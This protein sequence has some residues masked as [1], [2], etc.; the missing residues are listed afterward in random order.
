[1]NVQVHSRNMPFLE[2]FSSETRVKIIEL[3]G[4]QPMNIK[5]LAEAL[6]I[7]SAIVTK[8]IQK[9]EDAGIVGTES[10]SG[11]RG[12]RKVCRLLPESVTLQ[13]KTREL[14][15]R[16]RYEVSI[17]IG[18]YS[19]CQVKPT[20]GLASEDA[21]I[22]MIDDPRYFSDPDHIRAKHIWFGSGYLE[23]RIPNYLVGS[24]KVRS[25]S[26]SLEICSE[27]PGYNENWPSD[28]TFYLNGMAVGTWTC[29]GDFG[30]TPGVYTPQWWA[31]GTQHGLLKT[32]H[33]RPD[34][35]YM[36]GVRMSDVKA[37][38]LS[39][40]VGEDIRFRI[41]CHD[42]A[43]HCGGVSLFGRQFGNYDQEI[44]VAVYYED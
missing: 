36:D 25:L 43:R 8:H 28:L 7:S 27:A 38:D 4:E 18:Q 12:R 20:C 31:H 24:Q 13:F 2:C 16:D 44:E 11:T 9:L 22:G 21:V 30:S 32:I 37:G 5:E 15:D 23:Y 1:M 17:P 26:I 6:G 14:S 35:S 19:A 29:P 42:S 33:L 39:I 3:L 40:G 41:A 34:G 10:V